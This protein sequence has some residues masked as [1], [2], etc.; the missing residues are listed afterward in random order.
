MNQPWICMCSPSRSPLPPPSP[1]HP[2]GSSQGTSPEH[3]LA[4]LLHFFSRRRSD[5]SQKWEESLTTATDNS[6]S[7]QAHFKAFR[8]QWTWRIN[9]AADNANENN[10]F[11]CYLWPKHQKLLEMTATCMRGT[12]MPEPHMWPQR[13]AWETLVGPSLWESGWT[14][15]LGW[16]PFCPLLLVCPLCFSLLPSPLP[17]LLGPWQLAAI[18]ARGD[19][20]LRKLCSDLNKQLW[21]RVSRMLINPISSM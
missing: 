11:S 14:Q 19:F 16:I 10:L 21:R 8:N 4:S 9:P 15:D 18:T 3:F 2:S 6:K 7:L 20:S 17:V 5:T 12:M 1:S 13:A